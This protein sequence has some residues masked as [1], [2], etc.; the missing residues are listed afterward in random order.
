MEQTGIAKY[1]GNLIQMLEQLL[2]GMNN[3]IERIEGLDEQLSQRVA[4]APSTETVI[5]ELQEALQ[6]ACRTSFRIR[7]TAHKAISHKSVPWW[8]QNLQS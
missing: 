2:S 8:T 4:A 1:Q 5:E 6:T 7:N 3:E